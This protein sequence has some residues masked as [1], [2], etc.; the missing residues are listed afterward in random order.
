M[1]WTKI[2]TSLIVNRVPDKDILAITKYQLL[3][4]ELEHEPTEATA[5][6]YMTANQLALA[7]QYHAVIMA[8]VCADITSANKKRDNRRKNYIKNKDFYQNVAVTVADTVAPTVADTVAPQI[9][10]DKNISIDKSIL[11]ADKAAEPKKSAKPKR[12]LNNLQKFSNEVLAN[13]EPEVTSDAQKAVWFRR[14]CRCLTDILQFCGGNIDLA[15]GCIYV[16]GT[17]L[18]KANLRG[19]YEA[20]CRNLPDYFAEAKKL[21]GLNNANQTT[22]TAGK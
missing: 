18:Q 21:Q 19:G 2:H 3:W 9:R 20:V 15:L 14:N 1:E 4:A 16:C 6:R 8:D 13:F 17:R 12:Q 5:L 22:A 10:L 7:R 11:T